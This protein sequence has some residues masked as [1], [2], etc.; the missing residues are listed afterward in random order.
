MG[1]IAKQNGTIPKCLGSVSDHLHLC[2]SHLQ[3]T[4]YP[5]EQQLEQLRTWTFQEE[6]LAS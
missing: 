5:I 1:S 4:V 6:Y 2:V 3:E